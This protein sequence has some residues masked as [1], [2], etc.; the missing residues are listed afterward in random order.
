HRDPLV[1]TTLQGVAERLGVPLRHFSP[2]VRYC[3][4]FYGQDQ[5][6]ASTSQSVSSAALARILSSVP[7]GITELACH[8]AMACDFEGMYS[9]ERL[10]ELESLCDPA[11][12]DAVV[13][14]EITLCSFN[15]VRPIIA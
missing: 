1:H 2:D 7:S 8:P 14:H 10:L 11:I 3:G 4:D 13:E 15:R 12:Q 9:A 6:G 5:F